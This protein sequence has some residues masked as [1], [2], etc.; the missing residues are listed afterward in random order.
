MCVVGDGAC[1][2]VEHVWGW[3]CVGVG[4]V[5]GWGMCGGEALCGH[6]GWCRVVQLNVTTAILAQF[7][8]WE[9]LADIPSSI[10]KLLGQSVKH[11]VPATD[12]QID[13]QLIF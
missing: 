7:A 12:A 8:Y 4:H 9:V 10:T 2:G 13:F 1:V 5:W 11:G 6:G 3:G